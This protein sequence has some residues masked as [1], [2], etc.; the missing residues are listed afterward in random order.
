M[1]RAA[2]FRASLREFSRIVPRERGE[3]RKSSIEND[4]GPVG[5]SHKRGEERRE[6]YA[7]VRN[8]SENVRKCRHEAGGHQVRGQVQ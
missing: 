4:S 6:E 3:R 8:N 2:S 7:L 5:V 1:K